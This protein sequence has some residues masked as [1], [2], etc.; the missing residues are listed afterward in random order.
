MIFNMF[1]III[2]IYTIIENIHL[3]IIL[4]YSINV[5]GRSLK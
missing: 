3:N 1:I 5:T 4:E 2:I